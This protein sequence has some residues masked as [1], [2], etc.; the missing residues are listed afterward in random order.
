MSI[1]GGAI[2]VVSCCCQQG[3]VFV[4]KLPDTLTHGQQRF[5]VNAQQI[6][7]LVGQVRGHFAQLLAQLDH[8]HG[9]VAHVAGAVVRLHAQ[10]A[11][12]A[13]VAG[14]LADVARQ[15]FQA[16]HC[17]LG[18][19]A[20]LADGMAES[21]DFVGAAADPLAGVVQLVQVA[22]HFC[23]RRTS[24][25]RGGHGH[26]GQ[27]AQRRGDFHHRAQHAFLALLVCLEAQA[28]QKALQHLFVSHGSPV[29]VLRPQRPG[30][31]CPLS[32]QSC[33]SLV[34]RLVMTRLHLPAIHTG[35]FH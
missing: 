24:R 2:K 9:H 14:R 20:K 34:Q 7:K 6:G 27:I 19:A 11:Q 21:F 30:I 8:L 22:G 33:R 12:Q 17:A 10:P 35:T 25:S 13:D 4:G 28:D 1:T 29:P 31:C 26:S 18:A 3:L 5:F 15:V 16:G 32:C 23:N